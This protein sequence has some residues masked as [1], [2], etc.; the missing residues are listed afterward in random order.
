MFSKEY[1]KRITESAIAINNWSSY[2]Y[3]NRHMSSMKAEKNVD[4]LPKFF[5][6]Y[7]FSFL[8][9]SIQ[10]SQFQDVT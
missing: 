2:T 8:F 1:E 6:L 9:F 7:L 10:F 4:K 3:I 5:I